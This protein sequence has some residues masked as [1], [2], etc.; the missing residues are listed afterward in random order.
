MRLNLD[1]GA[2]VGKP[3]TRVN[4][5]RCGEEILNQREMVKHG[6][7]VCRSCAGESYWS[8]ME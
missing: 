2:I 6:Q 4:C 5:S 8:L 7:I 1:L 3:G